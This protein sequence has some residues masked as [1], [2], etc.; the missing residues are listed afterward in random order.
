MPRKQSPAEILAKE[1]KAVPKSATLPQ[2]GPV[3]CAMRA[4][5]NAIGLSLDHVSGELKISKA[6][7][8]EIENGGN[9]TVLNVL[10]LA[11]FYG[12]SVEELWS[13]N[14]GASDGVRGS[15]P[16]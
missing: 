15:G 12:R 5:R 6:T 14:E 11:Q 3:I 13:I 8:S 2:A 4:V 16:D 1:L 10:R 7:L 9:P